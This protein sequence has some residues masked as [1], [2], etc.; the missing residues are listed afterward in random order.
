M[1]ALGLMLWKIKDDIVRLNVTETT[2]ILI[3]LEMDHT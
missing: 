1:A 3:L 2:F